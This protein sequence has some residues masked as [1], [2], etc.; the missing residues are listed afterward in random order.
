[1]GLKLRHLRLRVQTTGGLFGVD[2]P[3]E[4]GLNVLWADNTKGK[5]T[6]VQSIVYALGLE[7]M[8][9]SQREIPLP[10]AM[11]DYLRE[12][13]DGS[14]IEHTVQ[15]S[16]VWLEIENSDKEIITLRRR[17]KGDVSN[18]LLSV[19]EGP[20]LSVGNTI[21]QAKDYFVR[22]P[23]SAT[24]EAGFHT[25]L[26]KFLGWHLPTVTKYD[27]G[28]APLYVETIFPLFFVEQ[29]LGWSAFPA[30]FPTYLGIRDMG[31]KAVEFVLDLDTHNVELERERLTQSITTVRSDWATKRD[32]LN[33]A[34]KSQG[35]EIRRFPASPEVGFS[36]LADTVFVVLSGDEAVSLDLAIVELKREL[37]ESRITEVPTSEDIAPE[38]IAKLEKFKDDLTSLNAR[39]SAVFQRRN[40]EYNQL[41]QLTERLSAIE[42]DLKANRDV[43]KLQSLGS[44]NLYSEHI[45]KCPTCDQSIA[46]A[47]LPQKSLG[48]VMTVDQNIAFLESQREIYRALLK[49]ARRTA[50]E[51]TEEL[52]RTSSQVNELSGTIRALKAD[53]VAPG[54]SPSESVIES[55]LRLE[56]KLRYLDESQQQ[57]QNI[58]EELK[59]ISSIYLDLMEQRSALPSDRWSEEDKQ[60][61]NVFIDKIREQLARYGFSTFSPT[62][63]SVSDNFRVEKE[64]FEIGFQTSASDSI[65]LKWAYQL[66]LL[67]VARTRATNH[68]GLVIFDEPRQQE[69]AKSSFKQLLARASHSLEYDQQVLFATSEDISEL[70]ADIEGIACSFITIDGWTLKRVEA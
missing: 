39:R 70:R 68:A 32:A 48:S 30:A 55:R 49:Q 62:E 13:V 20:V 22:D 57:L 64:G 10:Y 42:L 14:E 26:A 58:L 27:G 8:L 38:T 34:A 23:G 66:A 21:S 45:S 60:K 41:E 56:N 33:H 11:T 43:V 69:A 24:R 19:F 2:I 5:S 9:S 36:E 37:A 25:F 40:L 65:R 18:K 51:A 35:I 44:D 67:E 6:C 52:V 29:K 15:T 59:E 7:R 17:V 16:T 53:L 12:N 47:L 31:R 63:I 1:M 54:N 3:F 46:D 50:D 61:I 28:E 4:Q